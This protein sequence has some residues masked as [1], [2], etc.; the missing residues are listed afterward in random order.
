MS[1][2]RSLRMECYNWFATLRHHHPS[3]AVLARR[4]STHKFETFLE[5]QLHE[6]PSLLDDTQVHN[7]WKNQKA[8]CFSDR[9]FRHYQRF[10][11]CELRTAELRQKYPGLHDLVHEQAKTLTY[12]CITTVM[13]TLLK[14]KRLKTMP[15]IKFPVLSSLRYLNEDFDFI[16]KTIHN[17]SKRNEASKPPH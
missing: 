14:Q 8:W 17:W 11:C 6:V 7:V 15:M 3:F 5:G 1:A 10:S 16:L 13:Q 2:C 12:A 9:V 4:R